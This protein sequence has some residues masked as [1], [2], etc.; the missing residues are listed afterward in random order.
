LFFCFLQSTQ[1]EHLLLR[2]APFTLRD[3]ELHQQKCESIYAAEEG[4]DEE[5]EDDAGAAPAGDF[6]VAENAAAGNDLL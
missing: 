2:A 3:Q 5:F 4:E 6:H 1:V